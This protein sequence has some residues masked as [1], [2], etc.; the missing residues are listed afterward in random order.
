MENKTVVCPFCKNEIEHGMG[1]CL[2]CGA[3]I[4]YGKPPEWSV[5]IG[6]VLSVVISIL[7]AIALGGHITWFIAFA[8]CMLANV[9]INKSV[10]QNRVIFRR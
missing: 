10:F 9:L 8:I 3:S 1:V 4:I 7:I 6:C 2:P 5:I